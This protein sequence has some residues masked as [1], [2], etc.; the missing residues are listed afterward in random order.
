MLLRNKSMKY[1]KQ[2]ILH[3]K[4]AGYNLKLLLA[5]MAIIWKYSLQF[6]NVIDINSQEQYDNTY[7]CYLMLTSLV[8]W[9]R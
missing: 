3:N 9:L 2:R 6:L 1:I 4:L 5:L 8:F 7:I